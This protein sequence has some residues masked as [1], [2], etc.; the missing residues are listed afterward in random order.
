QAAPDRHPPTAAAAR[1]PAIPPAHAG[2]QHRVITQTRLRWPIRGQG[3]DMDV[4][5]V[6]RRDEQGADFSEKP[7]MAERRWIAKKGTPRQGRRAVASDAGRGGRP[8]M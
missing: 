2:N 7:E 6:T 8:S 5:R 3:S 1:I 4:I